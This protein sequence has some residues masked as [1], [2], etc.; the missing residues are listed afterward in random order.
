MCAVFRF[1][2]HPDHFKERY[3]TSLIVFFAFFSLLWIEL[4]HKNTKLTAH[5]LA[6]ILNI[7]KLKNVAIYILDL[8]NMFACTFPGLR[9]YVFV[10]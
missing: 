6:R 8:Y 10:Y 2:P 3:E 5:V 9:K 1:V 4:Q 7:I